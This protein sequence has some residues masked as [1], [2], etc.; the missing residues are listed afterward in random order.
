[1]SAEKRDQQESDKPNHDGLTSMSSQMLRIHESQHVILDQ[2]VIFN[3]HVIWDISLVKAPIN[4][5]H[6]LLGNI[7]PSTLVVGNGKEWG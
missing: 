3:S 7:V 5:E 1:M 6:V 4:L 2:N